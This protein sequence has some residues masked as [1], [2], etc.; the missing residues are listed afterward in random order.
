MSKPATAP[1]KTGTAKNS[2]AAI[3]IP[4]ALV[5]SILIYKFVMGA[6]SNFIDSNPDNNPLP[7]NYLGIVYKGGVIVPILMTLLI[8]VITFSIERL[9]TVGKASGKVSA[10]DFLSKTRT[11]LS[12]NNIAAVDQECDRQ[13][14]SLGNVVKAA[15]VKYRE[16]ESEQRMNKDQKIVAIQKQIEEATELEMPML[17]RNLPIISTIATIGTLIALLG[18]VLGM[19]RAFAALAQAG[20]PDSIALATGISEALVN[21]ALGIATSAI[22]VISYN[23]FTT[24]I[25][26]L[27]YAI[28]EAGFSIINTYAQTHN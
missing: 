3:V 14:G 8:L 16:V 23:Y 17:Q 6:S 9:M 7:G 18:T 11:L 13:A 20:A 28:D 22:A 10:H 25:D 21:T 5:I 19:I 26:G 24:R 4:V 1:Q 2:F 27:T 15:M 12:Q